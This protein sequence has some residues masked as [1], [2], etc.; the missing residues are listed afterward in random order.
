MPH[1]ADI[2]PNPERAVDLAVGGAEASTGLLDQPQRVAAPA[3]TIKSAG[4]RASVWTTRFP[5]GLDWPVFFW[6]VGMHIGA[7]AAFWFFSWPAFV[8]FLALHFVTACLGITLGFHRL[9]TH[10]SLV[11]PRPLK[12]FFSMC[13]M[14]SAEGSP[15]MWVANHRK[16]HA[17]SDM[18]GDPHSP[19][20]G[21]FWSHMF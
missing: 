1:E 8:T 20:D 6:M 9:L 7:V 11:V 12:Y 16:H 2:V 18:E 4:K 19:N 5:D 10:G 17:L 15:I 3:R 14:L 13:G 21:F